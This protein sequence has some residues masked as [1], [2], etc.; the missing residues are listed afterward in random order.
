[1]KDD[2][3]LYLEGESLLGFGIDRMP[4]INPDSLGHPAADGL[5]PLAAR[6]R[7]CRSCPLWEHRTQTVFGAGSHN[8]DLMFVGEAPGVDEDREG[9]PFVGRAGQ[10]LTRM[11]KA[12]GYKREEVYIA[13]VLKCRPPNN[14]TP[15]AREMASCRGYLDDQIRIIRPRVIVTLGTPAVRTLLGGGKGINAFR[16][17]S[18]PLPGSSEI[19]VVPTFHPAYLL[20]NETEKAKAWQDLKIALAILKE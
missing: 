4:G 14:R 15:T 7:E 1:M 13:N 2:K 18:Y 19:M 20:R 9:I 11:I 6:V 8:A 10:L 17:Q 12:M 5:P 3:H 16:G